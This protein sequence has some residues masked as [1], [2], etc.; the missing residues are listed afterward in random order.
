MKNIDNILFLLSQ[1]RSGSTFLQLLLNSNIGISSSP[2][3]SL[4]LKYIY[5]YKYNDSISFDTTY[6]NH[7]VDE[8]IEVLDEKDAVK[9]QSASQGTGKRF[10]QKYRINKFSKLFKK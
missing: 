5:N 4:L 9:Y 7:A 2:E 1:P 10:G 6:Y 8:F 3:S